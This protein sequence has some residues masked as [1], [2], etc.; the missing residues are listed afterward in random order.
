MENFAA[1]V[2]VDRAPNQWSGRIDGDTPEH[3]RWHQQVAALDE[4]TAQGAVAL[5]GFA[6]DAGVKRNAGR[7]GAAEG[8]AALRAALGSMAIH[9]PRGI[10]DAGDVVVRGDELESGQHRLAEAVTALHRRGTLPIVLGGGHETAYGSFMGLHAAVD[11][12]RIGILNLDAHFDLRSAPRRSSGTPFLDIAQHL[13]GTGEAFNYAIVG[14]SRPNNT[15]I[16]F[17]K[18]EQLSVRYLLDE[19]SQSLSEVSGFVAD[20][21]AEIDVL[22]LTIDLDVL[23]ASVAPG[24]SAP[25]GYGVPYEVIHGICR[26]VAASGK[27]GLVDVVELNPHFDVDARTA[28]SAARLIHT[29]ASVG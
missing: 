4:N 19:E 3:L 20:F 7:P 24:V 22:Y 25:A 18:A 28:R 21:L 5:L 1:P 29:L 9:V 8:P 6:S 10:V 11:G 14:I 27:L 2:K 15:G 12:A 23:P 16:L 17:D 13:Q 26:Q